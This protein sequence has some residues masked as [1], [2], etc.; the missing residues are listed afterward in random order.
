MAKADGLDF[1]QAGA[2]IDG[3]VDAWHSKLDRDGRLELPRIG[4]FYR[5]AERN[6]QFDPDRR[7]NFLKDA[8]GLRP[9]AAVPCVVPQAAPA[10]APFPPEPKVI[11]LVPVEEAHERRFPWLAA[12]AVVALLSTA[13]TWW[14]VASKGSQWRAVERVRSLRFDRARPSS[15]NGSKTMRARSTRSTPRLGR[16]PQTSRVCMSCRCPVMKAQRCSSTWVRLPL[17]RSSP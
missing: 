16:Y 13:A 14:V 9:V 6:L 11:P 4:T 2:V 5:D 12:A 3:E 8:Y 15:I 1:T 17:P 10:I 7:V